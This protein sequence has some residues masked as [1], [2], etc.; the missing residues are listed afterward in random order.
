MVVNP[1]GFYMNIWAKNYI[2]TDQERI[3][4]D[5]GIHI[6]F[7]IAEEDKCHY[8][9]PNET[10]LKIAE[11]IYLD[12]EYINDLKQYRNHPLLPILLDALLEYSCMSEEQL[13][14]FRYPLKV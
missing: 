8:F 7:Y 6:Y 1:K 9:F 12:K 4:F 5:T 13:K 2:S 10:I 3:K 14:N 11:E